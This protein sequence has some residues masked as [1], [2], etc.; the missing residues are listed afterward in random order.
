MRF[1]ICVTNQEYGTYFHGQENHLT[2]ACFESL[3]IERLGG[4]GIR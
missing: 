1:K 3:N 4:R 2:G